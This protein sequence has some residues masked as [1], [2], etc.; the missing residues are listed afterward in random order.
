MSVANL[1]A[2]CRLL[3]KTV[4]T[5]GLVTLG[6]C[7]WGMVCLNIKAVLRCDWTR[8]KLRGNSSEWVAKGEGPGVARR[9]IAS[10][11]RAE[12][13]NGKCYRD[14]TM[15]LSNNRLWLSLAWLEVSTCQSIPHF[16]I[17]SPPSDNYDGPASTRGGNFPMNSFHL[18][19]GGVGEYPKRRE[20]HV[21]RRFQKLPF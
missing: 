3:L 9:C 6:K 5:E 17:F 21:Q 4:L 18:S 12:S 1:T 11:W 2:A 7:H 15:A 20:G 10:S 14:C 8:R 19:V 13:D 16:C